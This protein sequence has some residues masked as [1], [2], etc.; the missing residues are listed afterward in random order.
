MSQRTDSSTHSPTKY[1]SEFVHERLD[2]KI[3]RK[4]TPAIFSRLWHPLFVYGTLKQKFPRHHILNNNSKYVGYGFT[5][6]AEWTMFRSK[7]KDPYPVCLPTVAIR[8]PSATPFKAGHVQGEVYLVPP[9]TIEYLDEIES[10]G[11]LFRRC[12][13]LIDIYA[14]GVR[15]MMMPCYVYIGIPELWQDDIEEHTVALCDFYY[16]KKEPSM[17]YY[18]YSRPTTRAL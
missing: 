1:V 17:G 12:L 16:R 9:D 6:G 15:S 13:R 2:E 11:F 4:D 14:K 5:R 8:S 18:L 7:T 3:Y 10:E